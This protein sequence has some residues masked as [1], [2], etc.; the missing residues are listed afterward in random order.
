ME[1]LLQALRATGEATRLRIVAVLARTELTVGELCQVLG[2]SQPRVSRHLKLLCEAGVLER[3]AQGTRAYFR[4]AR[5][6]LGRSV[7]D[8]IVPLIE[9]GDADLRRDLR[10]LATIRDDRAAAA[11]TYF[12]SIATD[13]DRMRTLH[14]ADETVEAAMLDLVDDLEIGDLLDVGTGTGRV[15]EVFAPHIRRGLG[16]DLSQPMLDV[17]RS[18]L[19]APEFRHCLVRSGDVYR[20]NVD[21]GAFDVAVLHH[22]LHFLDDPASAID[23]VAQAVGADGRR[24]TG[25]DLTT[26]RSPSGAMRPGSLT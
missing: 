2:Q 19:D 21:V 3:H 13:W 23:E 22:V 20:L 18:R 5:T 1:D 24:T 15:L 6:G 16:L 26:M 14:V 10:R 17:A 11:S 25:S 9:T 7:F 8:A 12:A 4:P